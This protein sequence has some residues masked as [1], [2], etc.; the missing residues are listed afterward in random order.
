[1]VMPFQMVHGKV[2]LLIFSSFKKGF[3]TS[4]FYLGSNAE[5]ST[6]NITRIN[7]EHMGTYVCEANNGI[8]PNAYQE[9]NV[10]VNCKQNSY[11]KFQLAKKCFI[12]TVPPLIKVHRGVVGGYNGSFAILEVRYIL[13]SSQCTH[14]QLSFLPSAW[15]KLFP[16][17]LIGGKDTMGGKSNNGTANTDGPPTTLTDTKPTKNS[18]LA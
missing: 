7:R 12:F 6:L 17:P 3:L 5:G 13:L 4:F 9:F 14:V 10:Q 18:T 11:E 15:L 16:W 1:M 2:R 8:S